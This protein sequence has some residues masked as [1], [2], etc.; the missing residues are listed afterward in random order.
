[1]ILL[2]PSV[3]V[4]RAHGD[5]AAFTS[6]IHSLIGTDKKRLRLVADPIGPDNDKHLIDMAKA[7][8][9]VVFA[10]GQ[11]GHASLLPRGFPLSL[12]KP[13]SK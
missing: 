1:M 7:A 13:D 8:A 12:S 3:A 9:V 2:S 4:S 5:M 11:P 10:Y 6:G